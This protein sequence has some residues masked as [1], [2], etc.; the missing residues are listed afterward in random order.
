MPR[1]FTL[2]QIPSCTGS[3][4]FTLIEL[5]VV[6]AVI[7]LLIGILLPSLG[8]AREAARTT[9][10]ASGLRQLGMGLLGYAND[11]RGAYGG[12]PFDNRVKQAWGPIDEASWVA[13][14]ANGGFAQPGKIL[15]PSSPAQFNQNLILNR[16]SDG[17][18][19]WTNPTEAERD[20]MIARGLNTNYTTCWYLAY[21]EMK[22]PSDPFADPMNKNDVV[23]PLTE[24]YLSAVSPSFVPLMGDGRSDAADAG[25]QI[26]YMGERLPTVKSMSDGPIK[27]DPV[28]GEYA[29]QDYDDLGPG[30]GG[31][32]VG[33]SR[34]RKKGHTRTIGN[35]AF[36]DG[37]VGSFRDLNND[38]EWSGD[39]IDGKFVYDELQGKVFGGILSSGK[40]W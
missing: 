3:R 20:E 12:G 23:G 24:K 38:Q 18:K 1:K 29:W 32:S 19:T 35:F 14:L 28:S 33:A 7:A 27:R 39:Y 10:C 31:R 2:S 34:S 36:A 8:A 15:C 4:A 16:I 11:Y 30:H 40:R 17:S 25:E 9:T 26:V 37:H 21:T 22:R 5:L 6:I 13:S